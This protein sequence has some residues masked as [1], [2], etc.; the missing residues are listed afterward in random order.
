MCRPGS[1]KR[2]SPSPYWNEAKTYLQQNPDVAAALEVGGHQV[3]GS[4]NI[5]CTAS[6]KIAHIFDLHFDSA[7]YL[8]NNPSV[9]PGDSERSR[10]I[11]V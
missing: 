2:R 7:Y 10:D 11:G 5:I 4:C 3:G 9:A 6:T 1:L 8:S